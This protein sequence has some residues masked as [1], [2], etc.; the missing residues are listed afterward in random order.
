MVSALDKLKR[1]LVTLLKTLA[2]AYGLTVTLTRESP[3][4][5]VTAAYRKVSRR[6][7]P[8]KRGGNGADQQRLNAAYQAW[9]DGVRRAPGSRARPA[10]SS[11]ADPGAMAPLRAEENGADKD[12]RIHSESVPAL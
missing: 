9:Q 11:S 4:K 7:H 2:T 6:V 3:D 10:S 12:Y 1:A 5:D 8:D